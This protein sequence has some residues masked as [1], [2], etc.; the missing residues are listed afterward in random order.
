[1]LNQNP[2]TSTHVLLHYIPVLLQNIMFCNR[3]FMFFHVLLQNKPVIRLR[4]FKLA[5]NWIYLEIL[6][7]GKVFKSH[8]ELN[9]DAKKFKTLSE[10]QKPETF[11]RRLFF[12]VM[13]RVLNSRSRKTTYASS[14]KRPLNFVKELK[15]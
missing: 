7:H 2:V 13:I 6:T 12:R 9:A 8:F 1:M 11:K 4:R 3:T 10:A 14:K 15:F 5:P